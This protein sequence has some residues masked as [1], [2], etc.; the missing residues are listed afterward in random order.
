MPNVILQYVSFKR[1]PLDVIGR[2]RILPQDLP[3]IIFGA[4][5]KNGQTDP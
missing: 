4:E 3:Q 2:P 1:T 5:P